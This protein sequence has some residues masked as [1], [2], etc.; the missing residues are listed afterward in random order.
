MVHDHL[1]TRKSA[2]L[3]QESA[4]QKRIRPSLKMGRFVF[5]DD[6]DRHHRRDRALSSYLTWPSTHSRLP[7]GKPASRDRAPVWLPRG[8]DRARSTSAV[9]TA[10]SGSQLGSARCANKTPPPGANDGAL[11]LAQ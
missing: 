2:S 7:S 10:L 9:Y 1:A 3:L 6:D 5:T 4:P 11:A 8:T